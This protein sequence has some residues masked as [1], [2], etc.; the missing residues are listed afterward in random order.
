M[1]IPMSGFA[2]K[3]TKEISLGD[4]IMDAESQLQNLK[5]EVADTVTYLDL[6]RASQEY[7]KIL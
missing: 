6:L 1:N 2:T 7:K 5:D 4:L 3:F